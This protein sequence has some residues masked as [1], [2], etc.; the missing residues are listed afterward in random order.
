M[1]PRKA[2]EPPETT[3]T[4]ADGQRLAR[5]SQAPAVHGHSDPW[6]VVDDTLGV[7]LVAV[8]TGGEAHVV[9]DR[10]IDPVTGFPL[11]GPPEVIEAPAHVEPIGDTG[12]DPYAEIASLVADEAPARAPLFTR[13]AVALD[14]FTRDRYGRPLIEQP[15]G[16]AVPYT[17]A[18]RMA[19]LV[20]DDSGLARWR[21]HSTALGL[22][23]RPD[24]LESVRAADPADRDELAR[25]ADEALE[26][27]GGRDASARGTLIHRRIEELLRDGVT[28][29]TGPEVD[30]ARSAVELLERLGL[31]PLAVELALVNHE[32]RAAGTADLLARGPSRV[33]IVD[34]KTSASAD[35]PRYGALPWAVQLAVYA[36]SVPYLPGTGATTWEALGLPQPDL[37]R[38]LVVHVAQ[39]TA[40]ARAYSVDL[41]RGRD[42]A[43]LAARVRDARSAARELVTAI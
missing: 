36:S 28:P 11:S 40:T 34:H 21:Q 23:S 2:V 8:P 37:E 26:A 15:D 16:S 33:L 22:A 18:S 27:G 19:S 39:G 42:A 20:D 32:L 31:E 12:T 17:R 6:F 7:Q 4:L 10:W 24:L 13:P 9:V 3:L 25:I 41:A 29:A 14:P 38:G 30:D 1:P 35:A 5:W 43:R